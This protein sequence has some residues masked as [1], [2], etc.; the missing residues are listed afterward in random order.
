MDMYAGD[1]AEARIVTE[2]LNH[3]YSCCLN[4]SRLVVKFLGLSAWLVIPSMLSANHPETR[5]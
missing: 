4:K 3:P 1:K 2:S 5:H